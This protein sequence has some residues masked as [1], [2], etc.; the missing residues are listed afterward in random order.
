[1]DFD[2]SQLKVNKVESKTGRNRYERSIVLQKYIENPL[3]IN[4]RKFDLRIFVLIS[5]EYKYYVFKYF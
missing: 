1:M 3:L 5:H 4:G 2:D